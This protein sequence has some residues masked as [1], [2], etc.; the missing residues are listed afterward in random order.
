MDLKETAYE[1]VHWIC[2][3]KDGVTWQALISMVMN[4]E[5]PK[6]AGNFL[7]NFTI[8]S[9]SSTLLHRAN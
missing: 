6:M 7:T 3:A 9:F 4:L 2:L 5:V 1:G 8:I